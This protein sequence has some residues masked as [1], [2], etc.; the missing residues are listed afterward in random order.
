MPKRLFIALELPGSVREALMKIDPGLKNVRWTHPEAMHLTLSFLG[1]VE[2]DSEAT[3]RESL[4]RVSV[5]PFPLP[6]RGVGTFGGTRPSVLWAGVGN[7]HPHLFALH[8]H[9]QDAILRAGLQA[10]LRPFHPHVTLAR[11]RGVSESVLR[12]FLRRHADT[13]FGMWEAKD[14]VLFSSELAPGGSIY[15]AEHRCLLK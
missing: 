11:P 14:F 8:K 4:D 13:E 15:R 12:P 2:S 10:D 9:L 7:G 1:D 5:A 6:I 3:L